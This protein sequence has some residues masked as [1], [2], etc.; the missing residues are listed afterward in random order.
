MTIEFACRQY[1]WTCR[2][3]NEHASV[4]DEHER[5]GK[6][7]CALLGYACESMVDELRDVVETRKGALPL[8]SL[9]PKAF[10]ISTPPHNEGMYTAREYDTMLVSESESGFTPQRRK[11]QSRVLKL[12][13][14]PARQS[15]RKKPAEVIQEQHSSQEELESVSLSNFPIG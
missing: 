12:P 9:P 4:V 11:T 13:K 10:Q 3:Y 15:R 5:Y 7:T 8:K 1:G 14:R 2:T 6:A